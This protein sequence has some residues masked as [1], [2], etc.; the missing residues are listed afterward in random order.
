MFLDG[1][2]RRHR[3]RMTLTKHEHLPRLTTACLK[4]TFVIETCRVHV[5]RSIVFRRVLIA[6]PREAVPRK[7]RFFRAIHGLDDE[8]QRTGRGDKSVTWEDHLRFFAAATGNE[9]CKFR[10]EGRRGLHSWQ[11]SAGAASTSPLSL[12]RASCSCSASK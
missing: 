6:S 12:W 4:S 11:S 3:Y 9:F 5:V 1:R 8:L 7:S 10:V 2:W